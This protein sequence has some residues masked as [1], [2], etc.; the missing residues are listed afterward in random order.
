[1][2]ETSVQLQTQPTVTDTSISLDSAG[3]P[4]LPHVPSQA[5]KQTKYKPRFA[6]FACTTNEVFRYAVTVTKAVIP[7]TFWGS[8]HN[9]EVTM[10][11]ALYHPMSSSL[12]RC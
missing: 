9:F 12:V 5:R 11:R 4:I 3:R 7:K 8:D 1:M 2:S 10:Q 6:E